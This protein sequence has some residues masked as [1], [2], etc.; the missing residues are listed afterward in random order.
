[1]IQVKVSLLVS[2]NGSL[3][4]LVNF[5]YVPTILDINYQVSIKEIRGDYGFM[6]QF[7]AFF[8]TLSYDN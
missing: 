2:K 4:F 3:E 8:G 7:A 5:V 1:M 6:K